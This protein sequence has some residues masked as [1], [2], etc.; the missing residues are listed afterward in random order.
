MKYEVGDTK[1]ETTH[2]ILSNFM[3]GP[4]SHYCDFFEAIWPVLD[5]QV[6]GRRLT[7]NVELRRI[8][9][10]VAGHMRYGNMRT[11]CGVTFSASKH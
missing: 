2:C 9:R 7:L 8:S 5:G 11:K 3:E 4:G 6:Q 1:N 10:E